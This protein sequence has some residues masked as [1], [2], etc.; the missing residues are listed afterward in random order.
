MRHYRLEAKKVFWGLNIKIWWSHVWKSQ[1]KSHIQHCE[2][3]EPRLHF[4]WTKVHQKCQKLVNFGEFFK[5]WSLRSNSGTRQITFIVQKI[6]EN[7]K[8]K[9]NILSHFQTI[10]H[11]LSLF[12]NCGGSWNATFWVNFKQCASCKKGI[13][14]PF[15]LLSRKSTDYCPKETRFSHAPWI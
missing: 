11:I 2:S 15:L 6:V 9:C 14:L 13:N 1:K 4:E 3:S 10:C 5:T 8:I 12:K 7:A